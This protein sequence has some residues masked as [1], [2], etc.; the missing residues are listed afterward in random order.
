MMHAQLFPSSSTAVAIVTIGEIPIGLL[1]VTDQLPSARRVHTIPSASATMSGVLNFQ[2]EG[3]RHTTVR[4]YRTPF[5]QR[6]HAYRESA[7]K[8]GMRLLDE[9]EISLE[10]ARRRGDDA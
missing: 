9:N 1:P 3:E 7:I 8:R 2:T 5:A 10:V 4:A 6:L